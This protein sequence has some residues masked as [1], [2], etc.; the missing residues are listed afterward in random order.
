MS[1]SARAIEYPKI[2]ILGALFICALGI[3]GI[4]DL[5]KERKPRIRLPV[6]MVA[7]PYP[8]AQPPEIERQIINVIEDE[9]ATLSNLSEDGAVLSQAMQGMALM[10]F[11]FN[12]EVDVIE[13]KRVVRMVNIDVT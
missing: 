9:S 3:A 12:H 8:G 11:V 5:P 7:V 1:L 6:V 4:A 13:A 10:Q 2:V